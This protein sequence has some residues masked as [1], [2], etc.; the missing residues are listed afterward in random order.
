MGVTGY[1]LGGGVGSVISAAGAV[2]LAKGL[3]EPS[4]QRA[5]AGQTKPQ[6]LIQNLANTPAGSAITNQLSTGLPRAVGSGE[7]DDLLLQPRNGMFTG[8]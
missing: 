7:L 4:V 2:G 8:Q 3:S 6:T 5:I 1:A